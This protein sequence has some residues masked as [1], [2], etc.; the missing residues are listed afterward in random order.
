MTELTQDQLAVLE[1]AKAREG[2][3]LREREK[4][5]E[6]RVIQSTSIITTRDGI[7]TYPISQELMLDAPNLQDLAIAQAVIITEQGDTILEQARRIEVLEAQKTRHVID[8]TWPYWYHVDGE[9]WEVWNDTNRIGH[10]KSDNPTLAIFDA[11]AF[12]KSCVVQS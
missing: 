5:R 7:T 9:L 11:I 12:I 10:G 2:E 4:P 6:E 1:R 3:Q 8:Y